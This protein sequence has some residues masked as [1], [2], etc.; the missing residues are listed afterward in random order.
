MKNRTF[1]TNRAIAAIALSLAFSAAQRA[2]AT[3]I[4]NQCDEPVSVAYLSQTSEGQGSLVRANTKGWYTVPARG[5]IE[6]LKGYGYL[7]AMKGSVIM[8]STDLSN[9]EVLGGCVKRGG[10]TNRSIVVEDAFNQERESNHPVSECFFEP[11]VVQLEGQLPPNRWYPFQKI[12]GYTKYTIQ[13]ASCKRTRNPDATRITWK[14]EQGDY[15]Y[16]WYKGKEFAIGNGDLVGGN[17][18][19]PRYI[20]VKQDADWIMLNKP[21]GKQTFGLGKTSRQIKAENGFEHAGNGKW[22]D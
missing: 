7:L 18:K 13:F 8:S 17:K 19:E 9:I 6:S 22:I 21:P 20:N 11:G 16:S 12:S 15:V 1:F 10:I 4:I 14:P 2:T 3:T 5:E